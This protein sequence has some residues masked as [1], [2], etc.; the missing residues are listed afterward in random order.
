MPVTDETKPEQGS[1]VKQVCLHPLGSS[2]QLASY[3]TV[4]DITVMDDSAMAIPT[5]AGAK[6]PRALSAPPQCAH[7]VARIM[8]LSL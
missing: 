7:F 8:Q 6:R 2:R 1:G 4:M 5:A 3:I